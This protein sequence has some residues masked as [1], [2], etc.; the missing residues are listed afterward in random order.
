[1]TAA[2]A[3]L[4]VMDPVP[5]LKPKKDT[6]LALIREAEKRGYACHACQIQD[7]GL[8]DGLAWARTQS[9]SVDLETDPF[10]TLGAPQEQPLATFR[11]ILMRKDPPVD[12]NYVFAT[13]IF[14]CAGPDT[15]PLNRPSALRD[16]NEKLA[17]AQFPELCAPTMTSANSDTLRAFAREQG[18]VV[19]KPLDGMGGKSIFRVRGDDPN[20][21]V[22]IETLTDSGQRL[23]MAQAFLPE[24]SDGDKRILMI[25]GQPWPRML[26]RIPAQGEAR[27]NLAA[28]GRGEVRD[29]GAAEKRIAAAVGPWLREQGV[30]FAGLDVIGDCLTEIN[31]TSPT[32]VREIEDADGS[33]ICAALWDAFESAGTPTPSS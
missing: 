22:V 26:A 28:G 29:L 24:I 32:C 16:L 18:Q 14:D 15:L 19:M 7:L 3:V 4:F 9:L 23:A 31:V 11:W 2:P 20:L 13:Q 25:N 8:R 17:I 10:Y 30:L 1:M 33:N 12:A 27:G 5:G 21:S 6:S